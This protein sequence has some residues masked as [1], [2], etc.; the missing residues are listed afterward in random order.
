ML[1]HRRVTPSIKFAGTHLYTWVERG[2][3]R[4]KCLAQEHNDGEVY[5][6]CPERVNEN[7]N[8]PIIRQWEN[9]IW[10]TGTKKKP[11]WERNVTQINISCAISFLEVTEKILA[12]GRSF[13]NLQFFSSFQHSFFIIIIS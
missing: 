10:V 12:F 7:R 5:C 8:F 9:V 6:E 2:T 4:I 11:Q 3:V 13:L 1:V